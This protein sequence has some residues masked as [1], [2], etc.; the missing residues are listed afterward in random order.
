MKIDSVSIV[1]ETAGYSCR[2]KHIF[3][4]LGITA[5]LLL[6]SLPYTVLECFAE[7]GA[8]TDDSS[9]ITWSFSDF[10]NTG[11]IITGCTGIPE[12]GIVTVPSVIGEKETARIGADTFRDNKSLK[13]LYL[14]DTINGFSQ[15]TFSGCSSLV[16]IRLPRGIDGI[17]S[18]MFSGCSSLTDVEIPD[19]VNVIA[20]D[21]FTGCKA[22]RS[23][24]IPAAVQSFAGQGTLFR[25]CSSMECISVSSDNTY[26]C[27]IDGV[28][29]NKTCTELIRYPEG[30]KD[31]RYALPESVSVLSAAAFA[32][33]EIE[34]ID[35]G[36][37]ISRIPDHC[38]DGAD[39]LVEVNVPEG[40]ESIGAYVFQNNTALVKLTLPGSLRTIGEHAFYYTAFTELDIPDG[41]TNISAGA[42]QHTKLIRVKLPDGL[43][44]VEDYLFDQSAVKEVSIPDS[45]EAIGRNP[46]RWAGLLEYVYIPSSVIQ[47]DGGS[48]A[49]DKLFYGAPADVKVYGDSG[50]YIQTYMETSGNAAGG[51]FTVGTRDEYQKTVDENLG[52]GSSSGDNQGGGN[53]GDDTN[54]GENTGSND[55]N[56]SNNN[57]GNKNSE[58][59][60]SDNNSGQSVSNGSKG[61]AGYSQTTGVIQYTVSL[62]KPKLKAKNRKG[63]KIKLSW[64]KVKGADG[65]LIFVKGPA[66][67]DFRCR[68]KKN[69]RVK[70]VTHKG[71]LKGKKYRYRIVPYKVINGEICQGPVSKTITVKVKR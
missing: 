63:R 71:L 42:F 8:W 59:E 36:A 66:D 11:L 41:V 35:L 48:S 26:F 4:V 7:S 49:S 29:F 56:G 27:D 10:G 37:K 5:A 21:A 70:S 67:R 61:S 51:S 12:N 9:G 14:P 33:A 22:L 60:E 69:A 20:N 25:G 16:K 65:Y 64:K 30:K 23:I 54:N 44:K 13:E 40:V 46:F 6:N 15:G 39:K 53:Q 31:Q 32:G 52:T 28:L 55:N 50:S 57:N 2:L 62:S 1:R 19:G 47:I 58:R 17:S 24:I 43:K 68:L 3:Y 45:V 38:F 18:Q 34:T